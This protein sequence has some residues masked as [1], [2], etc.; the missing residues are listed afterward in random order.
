MAG[1]P[2]KVITTQKVFTQTASVTT[3][4]TNLSD[5][6]NAVKLLSTANVPNGGR[7]VSITAI[8]RGS[9]GATQLQLYRS[10]D[11]GVTL[12]LADSA[13]LPAHTL[14]SGAA[15]TKAKFSDYTED[16]PCRLAAGE[17]LWVGIG[18]TVPNGVI[19]VVQYEA[20]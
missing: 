20:Y 15:I 7:A 3:A 17:E 5:T 8:G 2:N 16:S 1:T 9:V 10:Y 18:A 12:F 14:S 6:S 19:F 11:T 4:K 13:L